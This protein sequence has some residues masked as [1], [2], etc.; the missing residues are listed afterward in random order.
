M[1]NIGSAPYPKTRVYNNGG[2][3]QRC[4]FVMS[5]RTRL[6]CLR[7]LYHLRVERRAGVALGRQTIHNTNRHFAQRL[8]GCCRRGACAARNHEHQMTRPNEQRC[9]CV[10]TWARRPDLNLITSPELLLLR[11]Y[12]LPPPPSPSPICLPATCGDMHHWTGGGGNMRQARKTCGGKGSTFLSVGLLE[13]IGVVGN[14]N[15]IF[16]WA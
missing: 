12:L 7:F 9:W 4:R 11:P 13:F 8:A 5:S 14:N 6:V 16:L 1:A 15:G 3:W 10:W 2:C